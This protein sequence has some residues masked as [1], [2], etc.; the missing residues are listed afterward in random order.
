MQQTYLVFKTNHGLK[1]LKIQK[2]RIS[3][4]FMNLPL[5]VRTFKEL[6]TFKGVAVVLVL[7]HFQVPKVSQIAKECLENKNQYKKIEKNF[8]IFVF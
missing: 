5:F 3:E 8:E 4:S 7:G 2:M 6:G 1:L